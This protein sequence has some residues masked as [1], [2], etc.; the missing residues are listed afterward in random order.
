MFTTETRPSS[1]STENMVKT[2][3]QRQE[4]PSSS[5][6]PPTLRQQTSILSTHHSQ[7]TSQQNPHPKNPSLRSNLS[8]L[9]PDSP[10]NPLQTPP[11]SEE[12]K[13]PR[14]Q[15]LAKPPRPPYTFSKA[16]R[17]GVS[18]IGSVICAISKSS[19]R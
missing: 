9:R 10:P 6:P 18:H 15:T 7:I 19:P 5:R 13:F 1:S 16:S 4:I 2:L 14:L 11:L 12:F 17:L 3:S 8:P